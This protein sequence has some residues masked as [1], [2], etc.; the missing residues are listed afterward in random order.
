MRAAPPRPAFGGLLSFGLA[1]PLAGPLRRPGPAGDPRSPAARADENGSARAGC[2]LLRTWHRDDRALR[3]AAAVVHFGAFM[4]VD[5][6]RFR[7]HLAPDRES[8]GVLAIVFWSWATRYKFDQIYSRS[9][10][11]ETFPVFSVIG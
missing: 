10:M 5:W 7:P 4:P 6:R 1:L 11:L 9:E 2:L 3:F 8:D